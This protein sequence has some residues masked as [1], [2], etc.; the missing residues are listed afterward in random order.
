MDKVQC[1]ARVWSYGAFRS[2]PC[3]NTAK[4]GKFCGVHCP[5]RK[6]QRRKDQGPTRFERECAAIKS[7]REHIEGLEAEVSRLREALTEALPHIP[8]LGNKALAKDVRF[9]M[10]DR[11]RAALEAK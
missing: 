7:N 3:G 8:N 5:E 9:G 2:S 10:Q 1:E 4:Y 6:A 11:C